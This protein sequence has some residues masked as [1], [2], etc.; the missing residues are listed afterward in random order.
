[1]TE[2]ISARRGVLI[3]GISALA[4]LVL[5]AA[6][7]NQGTQNWRLERAM[8]S[9]DTAHSWIAG[10][11]LSLSAL[12]WRFTP[13]DGEP[14][15]VFL[16]FLSAALLTAV[17]TFLVMMLLCR[18]VAVVRGRWALFA[19]GWF[20]T[21]VAAGLSLIAGSAIAGHSI[22]IG[23][24]ASGADTRFNRGETYYGLLAVGMH[25]GLF[26]GWLVGLVAIVVY[27]LTEDSAAADQSS[28]EWG[29]AAGSGS[30]SGSG[31]DY[32]FKPTSPYSSSAPEYSSGYDSSGSAPTQIVPTQQ[33]QP[34]QE[35]DPY[36]GGGR[37]Y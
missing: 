26:A 16:G 9:G 7:D 12:D 1:M 24:T 34:P 11:V 27:G 21:A 23:L 15:R 14:T 31:S 5:I 4:L 10:P 32:S 29:S 18:G 2:N 36:G 33:P 19:A 28:R 22:G 37:S 20:A 25:F 30:G 6:F 35:N 8:Q 13:A 17:L 3:A